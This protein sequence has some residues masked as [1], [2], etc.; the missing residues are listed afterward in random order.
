MTQ[1]LANLKRRA[2]EIKDARRADAYKK[3]NLELNEAIRVPKHGLVYGSINHEI[4]VIPY[5][6]R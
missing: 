5:Q 2:A 4:N 6:E 1:N 3:H